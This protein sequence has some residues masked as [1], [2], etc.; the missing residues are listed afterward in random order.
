MKS[1]WVYILS[2]S[3]KSF[4]T[5]VTSNLQ[6]RIEEHNA[7]KYSGYTSKRLPVKL[8]YSQEFHDVKEAINAEKQIKGWS[9]KKKQALIMVIFLC[10]M[11]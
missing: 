2:C 8:V 6:N 7:G 11:N 5:G 3:D 1:Y 10:C 4:Y 9:R